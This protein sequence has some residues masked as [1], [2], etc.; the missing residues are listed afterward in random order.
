[1]SLHDVVGEWQVL[2]VGPARVTPPTPHGRAPARLPGSLVLPPQGVHIVAAGEPGP[3]QCDIRLARR[4]A[5]DLGPT[6]H[7]LRPITK[8]RR[9]P[10]HRRSVI[11][12][13]SIVETQQPTQPGVLRTK[14]RQLGTQRR[15]LGHGPIRP[16]R[17]AGSGHGS[18]TISVGPI[19]SHYPMVAEPGPCRSSSYDADP[20]RSSPGDRLHGGRHRQ[21][22]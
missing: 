16:S 1:M 13:L 4:A 11:T 7:R 10:R 18:L 21:C 6:R 9:R 14:L 12:T 20:D 17:P 22:P 3:E 2:A 5:V 19:A 8:Q 15:H